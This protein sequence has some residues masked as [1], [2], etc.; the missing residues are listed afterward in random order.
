[1]K[2]LLLLFII[3]ASLFASFVAAGCCI[4]GTTCSLTDNQGR[5]PVGATN[6][7]AGDCVRADNCAVVRDCLPG[8]TRPCTVGSLSG[9]EICNGAGAYTDCVITDSTYLASIDGDG[10]RDPDATDCD[11]NNDQFKGTECVE[12]YAPPSG[13]S[14]SPL[15]IAVIIIIAAFIVWFM[16]KQKSK[17]PKK[18]HPK[19]HKK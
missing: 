8:D 17:K 5:C 18:K 11:P 4:E 19:K 1:M 15:A 13:I 9:E 14:S 10:D 7:H 12:L 3:M 2:K 6:W 16:L